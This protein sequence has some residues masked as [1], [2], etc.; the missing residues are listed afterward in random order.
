LDWVVI[1]GLLLSGL[2]LAHYVLTK[3]SAFFKGL[4]RWSPVIGIALIIVIVGGAYFKVNPPA[5]AT[6]PNETGPP[7]LSSLNCPVPN[8]PITQQFGPSS[9]VGEPAYTFQGTYYHQFHQGVDLGAPTG[10]PVY[11]VTSG[12]ITFANLD[13]PRG[14]GTGYGKEI[15]LYD[16]H[17]VY[18]FGHLSEILV[19]QGEAVSV[20]H[21]IGKV[22]STGFSTGPHLHFGVS[23][24]GVSSIGG[25]EWVDPVPL[26]QS[27]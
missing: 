18:L 15:R 6:A 4:K 23:I 1:I 5:Q 13:Q 8:A 16:G 27:C 20:G 21:V 3:V 10:T 9:L 12:Q 2:L 14:P 24:N 19:N 22:G 17:S 25:G 7:V 11:A 26:M